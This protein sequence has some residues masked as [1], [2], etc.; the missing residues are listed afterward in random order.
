[1]VLGLVAHLAGLPVEE[2]LPALVATGGLLVAS[3]QLAL[4]R[5]GR[6]LGRRSHDQE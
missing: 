4:A 3:A 5:I 1:V 6:R 2:A